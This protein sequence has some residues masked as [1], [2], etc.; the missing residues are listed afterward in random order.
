MVAN[1]LRASEIL[2]PVHRFEAW[3]QERHPD[4][5]TEWEGFIPFGWFDLD[6]W[7]EE[8]HRYVLTEYHSWETTEA[9]T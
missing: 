2:D 8:Y 4:L 7:L 5:F 1:R 9:A 6:D 3:V